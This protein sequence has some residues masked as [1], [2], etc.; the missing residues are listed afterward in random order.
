M[1]GLLIKDFYNVRKQIIWYLLMLLCFCALSVFMHNSSF[2]ATIG[3]L[4][5]VSVL[6]TAFAYEEKDGWNKFAAASG[7]GKWTIVGEKYILGLIFSVLSTAAY[8]V[9]FMLIKDYCD[10]IDFILPVFMQLIMF[11]VM[12]PVVFRFGTERGRV[13]MIVAMI[14]L[15]VV[16]IFALTMVPEAWAPRL[17]VSSMATSRLRTSFSASKIRMMSMPFFTEYST[18]LRTTSSG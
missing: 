18:N 2:G 1:T 14:I 3:I 16:L 13:Y 7:M 17:T 6:L 4:V 11:A 12:L 5:T 15:M 10:W 9:A 8:L